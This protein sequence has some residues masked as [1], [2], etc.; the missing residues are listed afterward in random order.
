MVQGPRIREMELPG[1]VGQAREQ[2]DEVLRMWIVDR[3]ELAATFP[4][5]LYGDEVWKWGRVL[6]HLAR[7]IA[8][9]DAA[10]RGVNEA[11]SL[12]AVRASFETEIAASGA[13]HGGVRAMRSE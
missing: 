13:A 1:A 7:Y 2:A 3:A 8:K 9:A 10:R 6:A 5:D 11:D 4:A 12:E